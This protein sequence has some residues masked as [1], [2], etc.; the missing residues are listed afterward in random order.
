MEYPTD[1]RLPYFRVVDVLKHSA[2]FLHI[3]GGG[4]AFPAF[5]TSKELDTINFILLY[6]H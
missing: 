3:V 6:A 4:P 5:F 1:G 2:A